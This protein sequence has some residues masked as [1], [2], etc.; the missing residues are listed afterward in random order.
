MRRFLRVALVAVALG[1]IV[2]PVSAQSDSE[3]ES[4]I[5]R[6]PMDLG[7]DQIGT[8]RQLSRDILYPE[9]HIKNW[10]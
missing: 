5:D 3:S 9:H 7:A 6:P 4:I 1:A 8:L 2:S 10:F